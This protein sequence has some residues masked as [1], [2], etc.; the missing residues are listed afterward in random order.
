MPRLAVQWRTPRP[1]SLGRV[2]IGLGAVAAAS[3]AM[4]FLA[5]DALEGYV[6]MATTLAV[7][8]PLLRLV[9]EL[10]TPESPAQPA[11]S[12]GSAA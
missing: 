9:L 4:L 8:A 11:R 5:G 3:A 6:L 2:L 10:G 7:T 12:G 1:G